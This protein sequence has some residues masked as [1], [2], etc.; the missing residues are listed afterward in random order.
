MPVDDIF[1]D[2]CKEEQI[3]DEEILASSSDEAN[4]KTSYPRECLLEAWN[5]RKEKKIGSKETPEQG[6]FIPQLVSPNSKVR[7]YS[8]LFCVHCKGCREIDKTQN[9]NFLCMCCN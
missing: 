1:A 2:V 9:S 8:N 4:D 6:H 3:S 5:K 7:Y